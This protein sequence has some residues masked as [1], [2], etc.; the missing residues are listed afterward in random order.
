[1]QTPFEFKSRIRSVRLAAQGLGLTLR[2]Q[3]N[4]RIHAVATVA[5]VIAGC[6]LGISRTEWCLVVLACAAVWPAEAMNPA[7]EFL[8]DATTKDFH[9]LVGLAKDVAAGAVLISALAALV[10]GGLVF[11]PHLVALA[12][13]TR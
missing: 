6:G 5:A 4:A 9:P 7:V 1:M 2:S 13:L 11:G 8:G 12:H 3:P 10:V